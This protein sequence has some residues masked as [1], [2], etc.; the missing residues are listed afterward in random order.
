M[1]VNA[2]NATLTNNGNIILSEVNLNL[3]HSELIN[4]GYLKASNININ[5]KMVVFLIIKRLV[6]KI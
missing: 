5:A 4:D 3:L 6:Q 1:T 2:K